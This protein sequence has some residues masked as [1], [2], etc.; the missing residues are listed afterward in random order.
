[1]T[2][3]EASDG[4][5]NPVEKVDAVVTDVHTGSSLAG[6]R[7]LG[8][9]GHR[10]L[11]LGDDASAAGMR[12]RYATVSAVAPNSDSDPLGFVRRVAALARAHGPFVFYPAG[13]SAILAVLDHGAELPSAAI[14]PFARLDSLRELRDKRELSRLAA[15]A[16]LATPSTLMEATAAEIAIAPPALPFAVKQVLPEGSLKKRT[17]IIRT[18]AQLDALVAD[19]P[20]DEPLLLQEYAE[21]PLIG[22]A[23][24]LD[25]EGRLIARLQQYARR[26]WPVEA[27]GSTLAVSMAPDEDLVARSTRM[28]AATGFTGMAQLQFLR[29]NRGLALIDVNPRFYGSMALATASGVNLAEAWHASV[30]GAPSKPVP[31]YRAGVSYRWLEGDLTAALNGFPRRMFARTPKPRTGQ[32]WAS[33]DPMPGVVI[34]TKAIEARIR[35]RLRAARSALVRARG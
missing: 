2:L 20:P 4:G 10:V 35:Q 19:V 34:A 9:A 3:S 30:M 27:G 16:G 32:A 23:L 1:M 18:Q 13:E 14:L 15:G 6:L 17:R 31:A 12:S 33:D 7:D 22:L 21:G 29:T 11:T 8:R 28:L 26:L 24:V 5:P 25:G